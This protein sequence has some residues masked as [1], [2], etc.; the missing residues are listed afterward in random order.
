M[1]L[2]DPQSRGLKGIPVLAIFKGPVRTFRCLPTVGNI[3]KQSL[4][5]C[6]LFEQKLNFSS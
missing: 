2:W 1:I 4:L 6:L 5:S 3:Q